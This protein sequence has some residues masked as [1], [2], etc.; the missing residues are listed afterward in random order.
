MSKRNFFRNKPLAFIETK[1]SVKFDE[2]WRPDHEFT[3]IFVTLLLLALEF[4]EPTSQ[5]AGP[6]VGRLVV[7]EIVPH[8]VVV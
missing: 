8:E 7:D 5:I 3:Y 6:L 2:L 4:S 1:L